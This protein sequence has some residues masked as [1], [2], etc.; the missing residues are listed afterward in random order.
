VSIQVATQGAAASSR[1]RSGTTITVPDPPTGV[2]AASNGN[3]GQLLVQWSAPANNGGA[4]V[5]DYTVTRVGAGTV[6]PIAGLS[7]VVTGLTNGTNYTFTVTARNSVGSSVAS[8]ASANAAP[9]APTGTLYFDGSFASGN[10]NAYSSGAVVSPADITI[11]NDPIL[12][13][14]RKVVRMS[15]NDGD[16]GGVTTD[17]RAQ[18]ETPQLWFEGDDLYIGFGFM[19]DATFPSLS[20]SMWATFAQVYGPPWADSAPYSVDMNNGTYI[21]FDG[22]TDSTNM[23]RGVWY[24]FVVHET[25]STTTGGSLAEMWVNKGSGYVH[26]DTALGHGVTL[27]TPNNGGNNYHKISNYTGASQWSSGQYPITVYFSQHKVGSTFAIVDPH[28]Y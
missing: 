20:S 4:A 5:I 6:G 8:A 9:A 13:T 25:L 1:R 14:A 15:V 28:S 3:S 22:Y 10:F 12:G 21:E 7:T 26:I 11:I 18:L 27:G 19:L 16:T 24:D 23:A 2:S 17:N